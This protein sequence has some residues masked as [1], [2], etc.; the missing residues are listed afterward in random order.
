MTFSSRKVETTHEKCSLLVINISVQSTYQ[1]NHEAKLAHY[2]KRTERSKVND[3]QGQRKVN[4]QLR[5]PS[6]KGGKLASKIFSVFQ[7]NLSKRI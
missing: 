3:P 4:I 1:T 5:Q 7:Y 6:S 2:W